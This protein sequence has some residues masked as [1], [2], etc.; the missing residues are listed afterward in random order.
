MQSMAIFLFR[1]G[2]HAGQGRGDAGTKGPGG[3]L[4][5][6]K[7]VP[8]SGKQ[9]QWVWTWFGQ[10]LEPPGLNWATEINDRP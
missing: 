2:A 4:L 5:L 1:L 6:I 10:F 8:G 9:F 7:R 3:Y